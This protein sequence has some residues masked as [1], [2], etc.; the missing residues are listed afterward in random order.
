[1]IKDCSV[2]VFSNENRTG[3]CVDLHLTGPAVVSDRFVTDPF[4]TCSWHYDECGHAVD[5]DDQQHIRAVDL[6]DDKKSVPSRRKEKA[7]RALAPRPP[8]TDQT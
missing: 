3:V 1:M 7:C 6:V 4:G 5:I 2:K 8:L